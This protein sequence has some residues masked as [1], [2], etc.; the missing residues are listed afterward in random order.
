MATQT[1]TVKVRFDGD[2]AGLK[3]SAQE[4][5]KA[6][7][8]WRDK[9]NKVGQAA[10]VA[11][12]AMAAG[13]V[14][15]GKEMLGLSRQI[16]L[17]DVKAKTVFEGQL[18]VI[19]KWA[20]ANAKSF[21]T[22]S[23]QVVG[24]AA[25]MADLLKPM[26]FTAQQATDM[27]I[28]MLDLS[29]ALAN[30]SGG[31]RTAAEVSDILTKALLGE[32]EELKSLGISISEADVQARLAAKG[33]D[34]LTGAALA[35]A[36]ALAT[37]ELIL[38]KS[39]D[40][41]KAWADGGREAAERAGALN[42][43][44]ETMKE[45]LA[46]ALGPALE[47][48]I[49]WLTKFAEW[50]GEHPVLVG[51]ILAISAALVVLTA[52]LWAI[53][54]A[55]A[56]NP[57]VLAVAGIVLAIGLLVAGLIWAW[58]NS[59]TFRD[60]VFGVFRFVRDEIDRSIRDVKT[61]LNS[62]GDVLRSV[63]GFFVRL[64]DTAVR[65]FWEMVNFARGLPGRILG[66]LGY[67]GNLLYSTGR[68]IVG[69]IWRGISNGWDWLMDQVAGLAQRLL[70]RAKSALGIASPSKLFADQIGRWI[71]EGI[72]VGVDGNTATATDSIRRVAD[73]L[74]TAPSF[75]RNGVPSQSS[76]TAATMQAGD[77]YVTV[78]LDGEPIKATIR[79]EMS[80]SNRA[81]KRGVL[82]GAGAI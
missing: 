8:G 80:E 16:E 59:E 72:A 66:A 77:T 65:E 17:L 40:A 24:L 48:V 43:Q 55:L 45:K 79:R 9:F 52:A 34:K 33:Q 22:T 6:V 41:Q 42:S 37:Q 69:G 61:V 49:G 71:P 44:I 23:R 51:A 73:S 18:P 2:A 64:K 29:G 32:R 62:I 12:A 47:T 54:I 14:V 56:A 1:R 20:D 28:K 39:T 21:G 57:I 10:G 68:D 13:A 60:I 75:L 81:L 5:E 63:G 27:S 74:L 26:G 70:N 19:Q 3:R 7:A 38:E 82:A 78:I 50:A 31:Q 76:N 36:T 30:W 53:N 46:V 58:K 25:N 67:L 11:T 4:G 15:F 35:Q